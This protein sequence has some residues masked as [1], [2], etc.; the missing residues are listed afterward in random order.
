M[1][2]LKDKIKVLYV[3]MLAVM[4]ISSG[5][6][7]YGQQANR[8]EAEY[9]RVTKL[10]ES[11][12]KNALRQL[13]NYL[14]EYPYTTF[15]AE[16]YFMI[17][18]IQTERGYYKRAVKEFERADYKD[19]SRA[20]QPEY[21]FYR[22]YAHLMQSDYQKASIYFSHLANMDDAAIKKVNS[23]ALPLK[24]KACYYYA[25]CQYKLGNYD[26]ALPVLKQLEN[27]AEYRKTVPY[28]LTQIYYA[29]GDYEEARTRAEALLEE[30]PENENNAELH[31]MLGETYYREGR[32]VD[33]AREL[34]AY[35]AAMTAKKEPVLRND[36]YMLAM[37]QYRLP[38]YNQAI[39]TFKRVEEKQ[40]EVSED[41][42][43]GLGNA[44][45]QLGEIEQAKLAYLAATQYNLNEKVHYEAMYNYA[46]AVY[47]SSSS[48]GES[49]TVFTDF[50]KQYPNSEHVNEI[51]MLLSD[52]FRRAK[53][54]R[55]AL[56]ALD[57]V[58][59]PDAKLLE[60]KQYLRY[61]LGSDAFV[62]GKLAE[63]KE[64]FTVVIDDKSVQNKEK[65][66][67]T[68]AYYWR[69]E[70]E[71]RMAEYEACEQDLK[72]YFGRADVG[73]SPNKVMADYLAGYCAFQQK[74]Y[75][76]ARVA[77]E[78]HVA[79]A[80]P[81]SGSYADALNRI[82]DCYFNGR[83]FAKANEAYAKAAAANGT[84]ADYALFQ[85]GYA[86]G[87]QKQWDAKANVL[88]Q[89]VKSY[90]K[91]DYADNA[92]YELA[93]VRMSQEQE[94]QAIDAYEQ[95]LT[96]YPRSEYARAASLERAMAYRNIHEYDRAMDAYKQT[97]ERYP[98]SK[99]AYLAVEGLEAVC[100]TT[101]R[102]N[103]YIAYSKKLS[104][105]NM[106]IAT[107]DDSLSYVAAELQLRQGNT[108][109]A[110][111]QFAPLADRQGSAY[112]EP[113]AVTSAEVYFE[114]KDYENALAFYRKSLQNAS[115]RK[116]SIAA[117]VGILRCAVALNNQQEIIE[118]ASQIL[119]DPPIAADIEKEALFARAKAY[120][121]TE[122]YG[123][124]VADL[125]PAS[126]D[127]RTAEGAEAKYML[128]QSYYNL[129]SL[130]KAEAE[131]MS[132]AQ[133]PTQQQYWLARSL[134]VLASVSQQR[135]DDFQARQ[136]LLSLKT[137]Y[138]NKDDIM[139]RV[140][141]QLASLTPEPSADEGS[142]TSNQEEE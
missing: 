33:A 139:D 125:T 15:E 78:R 41:V 110:L 141:A 51:Y 133:Q 23:Q 60:T 111:A 48:I 17:G 117:K 4:A 49:E 97:I 38:D 128:A 35:D 137:N 82:G 63:A 56:S 66:V 29:N 46:L 84:G 130:D 140:E 16:L 52:A 68:D 31:R 90:P 93:R 61:Q 112:A 34:S 32:Y 75:D 57:S 30:Q 42:S 98:A 58:R 24:Q 115:N 101:N 135:G 10:Y 72:T 94:R 80:S 88:Q 43:L 26:K 127:V 124:A 11:R 59:N 89:L 119:S 47:Q 5:N 14:T 83:N 44:Y 27:V 100:I 77:F 121:A 54:Y 19:L 8:M 50:I 103:D 138:K 126:K 18:V 102:V 113:A 129:G 92:L 79:A 21:Q 70:T 20:H 120:F 87:L 95:L 116:K 40:D 39:A 65:S 118:S 64:W 85:Q 67:Q 134:L 76:E 108:D 25:Y 105:L 104:K 6:A 86:L 136:Y 12:D 13:R 28:Y 22:G 69:A 131:V 1:R 74:K 99:E 114:R 2:R 9:N 96:R 109:A 3:A 55:A 132:F 53:N 122:Q 7:V 37:S 106:E 36:L 142:Q 81:T 123:L 91:S 62:R 45:R 107:Q 71:Y 73:M